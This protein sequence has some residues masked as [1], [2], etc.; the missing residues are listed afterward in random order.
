MGD[1]APAL[2]DL[3]PYIIRWST[4]HTPPEPVIIRHGRLAYPWSGTAWMS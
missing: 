2:A 1:Q 3:V 4:E